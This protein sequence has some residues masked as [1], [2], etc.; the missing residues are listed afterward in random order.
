MLFPASTWPTTTK[1]AAFFLS[2]LLNS[3]MTSRFLLAGF[4]PSSILSSLSFPAT[5]LGVEVAF[6]FWLAPA[7]FFPA[8]STISIR[9]SA[10]SL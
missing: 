5:K 3:D 2:L 8:A 4:D 10:R 1:E 6:A 9:V 7:A